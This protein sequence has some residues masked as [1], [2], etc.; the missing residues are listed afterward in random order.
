MKWTDLLAMHKFGMC[1]EKK[2]P[3]ILSLNLIDLGDL[4]KPPKGA[5][6]KGGI[7]MWQWLSIDTIG[8]TMA[9]Q[10]AQ[11]NSG[12]G[13]MPQICY[14]DLD[15]ILLINYEY[16]LFFCLPWINNSGI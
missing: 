14:P 6:S 3:S 4:F 2:K 9:E 15:Y 10:L 11:S 7:N 12:N 16:S 1:H 8:N 13:Y 5:F